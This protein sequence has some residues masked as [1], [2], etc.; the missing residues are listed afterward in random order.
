[1]LM[2]LPLYE[3]V[4]AEAEAALTD[5]EF[6]LTHARL[7]ADGASEDAT[8][9]LIHQITEAPRTWGAL[10]AL[11]ARFVARYGETAPH[12]FER[13]LLLR[14]F[15][16]SLRSLPD[17]T[18]AESVKRLICDQVQLL[19]APPPAVLRRCDLRRN[20]FVGLCKLA[21]LRRLPAGQLTWE[22]GG[23]PRSWLLKIPLRDLL[24]VWRHIAT[25]MRGLAPMF[26][27]HLSPVRKDRVVLLERESNRAYYRMAQSLAL[28]PA[29][30]GLIASS[31]LHSTDTMVVSPHLTSFSRV[32]LENGGV[33]TTIGAADPDC[34]VFHRSPERKRLYDEGKFKP[35]T[36]LVLW[37]RDDMLAWAAAHPELA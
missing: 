9:E 4:I 37:A 21:T 8:W 10:P 33:I 24:K 1:M 14:G 6:G 27:P 32:I 18:V 34:G 16:R 28:Q 23:V 19:I 17:L 29:V 2:P 26:V 30:K 11:H 5:G 22:I 31:W 7:V 13:V 12:T 36:G 3:Q 15:K 35:T 20:S 25:R